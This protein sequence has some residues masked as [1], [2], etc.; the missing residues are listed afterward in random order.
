MSSIHA[1]PLNLLTRDAGESR[2]FIVKPIDATPR[3]NIRPD[4]KGIL[5]IVDIDKIKIHDCICTPEVKEQGHFHLYCRNEK[6]E[7]SIYGRKQNVNGYY[8]DLWDKLNT[9][10]FAKQGIP[11]GTVIAGELVYPKHPDSKVPTAIKEFPDRLE[12][13]AFAVPLYKGTLLYGPTSQQYNK[14]RKLLQNIL[15]PEMLVQNMSPI[16][17]GDKFHSAKV[18]QSLLEVAK[19]KHIEGF[20]LKEKAYDQWWKIKTVREAD[21][22]VTGFKVSKSDTQY[23]LVTAISIAVKKNGDELDMGSVTGFDLETKQNM[24]KAFSAF[25]STTRNPYMNR[26]LRVTYQ[27]IAGKGKLKHGFF[28]G[29]R[30]DKDYLDCQAEQFE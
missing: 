12:F 29:W 21:V 7:Y 8:I 30:D 5:R 13:R 3:S 24:T 4:S 19:I 26:C 11:R 1:W 14:G 25:G 16:E 18:L 17:F 6:G 10:K 23:G 27:E 20:V 15:P 2:A 28:D 9:C 22:Y